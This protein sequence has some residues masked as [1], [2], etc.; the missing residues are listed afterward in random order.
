MKKKGI[1][2]A[3]SI[4]IA[5]DK[6]VILNIALDTEKLKHKIKTTIIIPIE[7]FTSSGHA[8]LMNSLVFFIEC[9]QK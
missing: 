2:M 5:S 7:A 4:A 9:P 3:K 1:K 6:L 8:F